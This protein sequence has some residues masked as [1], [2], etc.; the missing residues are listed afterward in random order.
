MSRPGLEDVE[1]LRQQLRKLRTAT[2]PS[3]E[4]L[5][6]EA[7]RFRQGLRAAV[8]G[9]GEAAEGRQVREALEEAWALLNVPT[10]R[11]AVARYCQE[12]YQGVSID[13][14]RLYRNAC[15]LLA[16]AQVAV[17]ARQVVWDQEASAR[18]TRWA[19]EAAAVLG[20]RRGAKSPTV[21]LQWTEAQAPAAVTRV[22]EA[23]A[24]AGWEVTAAR[25]WTLHWLGALPRVPFLHL[26]VAGHHQGRGF[27]ADLALRLLDKGPGP[28][29]EDPDTAFCPLG[30][31]LLE[32]LQAAWQR[33]SQPI[34]WRLTVRT[35]D[36]PPWLPLD[37]DSLSGAA[38][39]GCSLLQQGRPYDQQHLIVGRV[40][41]DDR[42]SRVGEETC[43]LEAALAEGIR[44]AV[45][46]PD[47][48]LTD[49]QIDQF[50]AQGMA[51][52]SKG[53]LAEAE[54]FASGL[55]TGVQRLLRE[56][57]RWILE[58]AG[59]R[60]GRQLET[61][62][63]FDALF[64]PVQVARGI[65][66]RLT[67][68]EYKDL[69]RRR[70]AGDYSG[71]NRVE[72]RRRLD[73]RDERLQPE[74]RRETV[75]WERVRD[76]LSRSVVLGDPGYGKT[77]LLWH[78][79]GRR[80][81]Q[82]LQAIQTE[83]RGSAEVTLGVFVRAVEL[84]D[85]LASDRY[86]DRQDPERLLDAVASRVVARHALKAGTEVFLQ[87]R[88]KQGACL[89]AVDAL[90][91]V[92][93]EHR[94]RLKDALIHG[95]THHGQLRVLLSAR[96][97]G[98]TSWAPVP[99]AERDELEILAFHMP[100]M[101]R[102]VQAWFAGDSQTATTV[103]H[104]LHRQEA[105]RNVL[106]CPL[107]LRVLC[108]SIE[109]AVRRRRALPVFGRRVE[110]YQTFL[111]SLV[112]RWAERENPTP[113]ERAL[114]L[115]LAGEMAARLWR[116][117]AR[118]T[119]WEEA[120][121][122]RVLSQVC[123]S[124]SYRVV[125]ARHLLRDLREAGL[126]VPAGPDAHGT[127]LMFAHRTFGEY[128]AALALVRQLDD[129]GSAKAVWKLLNENAGDP[130]WDEVLLFLAGISTL[131]DTRR[132]LTLLS[133]PSRDSP[134]RHRLGLAG[135]CLAELPAGYLP[136]L[137]PLTDKI[138]GDVVRL[139]QSTDPE[140]TV[141]AFPR[142]AQALGPLAHAGASVDGLPLLQ[143]VL[144]EARRTPEALRFMGSITTPPDAA[145][146]AAAML[147][148]ALRDEDAGVRKAAAEALELMGEPAAAHPGV[149]D[150]LLAQLKD[151]RRYLLELEEVRKARLEVEEGDEAAGQMVAPATADPAVLDK[152]A[153]KLEREEE[154]QVAVAHALGALG[155]SAAAHPDVLD[156]L[157]ARLLDK[158]VSEWVVASAAH[159]LGA[160]GDAVAAHPG[161]L[162][163]LLAVMDNEPAGTMAGISAG[164]S[165]GALGLLAA[166][167]DPGV[168]D[169][170][171][172]KLLHKLQDKY[173]ARDAAAYAL[174]AM[175]PPAVARPDVL[176][177]LLARLLDKAEREWVV[178]SAA[179]ALGALGDAAAAHPGV[180]D[181]LFARYQDEVAS[182]EWVYADSLAALADALERMG[183]AAA[184]RPD[185]LD[186]LL[187]RL[188]DKAVSP[189]MRASAAHALGALGTA[190]AAHPGII[191]ALL[192]RLR[193]R[194]EAV[195]WAAFE[196]LG[197]MGAAAATHPGVLDVFLAQ[198]RCTDADTDTL[199]VAAKALAS[200]GAAAAAHPGVIDALFARFLDT[201]QRF[202]VCRAAAEALSRLGAEWKPRRRAG[203]SERSH[204][205][206]R[207]Q[208]G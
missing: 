82:G 198:L 25:Y 18:L 171:L 199:M 9:A 132:L 61:W 32:V 80:C 113:D 34:C 180:I 188:L 37:G 75:A 129:P 42:L 136:H 27:L 194:E 86:K 66:P 63:E 41:A 62:A 138:A 15:G 101:A 150:A 10:A 4:A 145:S 108:Q 56:E 165:L 134:F 88:L 125:K 176:D 12:R 98:Y 45:V 195:R 1:E 96:L 155:A 118:R 122:A 100:Q 83:G 76:Q 172:D 16:T 168:L 43:K 160:L 51:V 139:L 205:A 127:P 78:E 60:L 36:F 33:I 204:F 109:V 182:A 152:L 144:R 156:A 90:D 99:V 170:L 112:D 110:L 131:E 103:W 24:E 67:E 29:V 57:T 128:L 52:S 74:L 19:Q 54:E 115:D 151:N 167:A 184:A 53:T 119:L 94:A 135:R 8:A 120:A 166:A 149:L 65:R 59:R 5:A 58:D 68:A 185:V 153:D 137:A 106:R 39:V 175:G 123:A 70:A 197:S 174:G 20:E 148:N 81:G 157:L 26:P 11:A 164:R 30:R 203:S 38:V 206:R 6:G 146:N 105:V 46:A 102:A 201:H 192:A 193:D 117:D 202:R 161:V 40:T 159:A 178:A 93:Q 17:V 147:A 73:L 189:R 179:H 140:L 35:R 89:L 200:M 104:H 13:A 107:L 72:A 44:Y 196:A 133:E 85:T 141:T 181:A 2:I 84:A 87:E 186:A 207:H 177:A 14:D 111:E 21:S 47:T 64:V 143:W 208:R 23:L 48:R 31:D 142:A 28:L 114:F 71:I 7:D 92:P 130:A 121:V 50:G 173:G 49:A 187:A 116:Q 77:M 95:M 126:L 154:V 55:L 191:D 163:A 3:W 79:V 124:P 97:A 190:A 22:Y 169:G 91:E 162:D 69:E 158:A 183:A